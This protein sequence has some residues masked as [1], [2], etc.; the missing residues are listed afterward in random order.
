MPAP[1]WAFLF[2][3]C[4]IGVCLCVC[5]FVL[6]A[7]LYCLRLLVRLLT[8][9]CLTGRVDNGKRACPPFLGF[10]LR[11]RS[12]GAPHTT[13]PSRRY[14]KHF[15][16]S[17]GRDWSFLRDKPP[18]LLDELV[19]CAGVV[20]RAAGEDV[21]LPKAGAPQRGRAVRPAPLP[22]AN[23]LECVVCCLCVWQSCSLFYSCGCTASCGRVCVGVVWDVV[24]AQD[25]ADGLYVVIQ[26]SVS[27]CMLI[28]D[29]NS[30]EVQMVDV[31][32]M[33]QQLF[34]VQDLLNAVKETMCVAGA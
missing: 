14:I 31:T 27:L 22:A 5:L 32:S 28:S 10:T 30:A 25:S 2:A 4:C 33:R 23:P 15:L 9:C 34:Q 7:A 19:K 18:E 26:G 16:M 13:C 17:R 1:A 3:V 29:F 11:C 12:L 21:F 8:A 20:E 6:T 24:L